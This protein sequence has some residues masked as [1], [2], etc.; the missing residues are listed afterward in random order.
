MSVEKE[1][2][3]SKDF[4]ERLLRQQEAEQRTRE[5]Q[6]AMQNKAE[7]DAHNQA[8]AAKTEQEHN[9]EHDL[10]NLSKNK[11]AAGQIQKAVFVDSADNEFDR[12]TGETQADANNK[13]FIK[14][15]MLRDA[16]DQ[17]AKSIAQMFEA[18]N[19]KLAELEKD[20]V[21]LDK[22]LDE[23]K[24]SRVIA[25]K[26]NTAFENRDFEMMEL[27][28]VQHGDY[29]ADS[30]K[31]MESEEIL[32]AFIDFADDVLDENKKLQLE[33]EARLSGVDEKTEAIRKERQDLKEK[34][35]NGEIS[36]A[37]Y[38]EQL[39]QTDERY[40]KA[41]NKAQQ[42]TEDFAKEKGLSHEAMQKL[43]NTIAKVR[44]E[45]SAFL[46]E[47]KNESKGLDRTITAQDQ[48]PEVE[49]DGLASMSFP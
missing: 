47:E 33:L 46:K 28:M 40:G 4:A 38:E 22:G 10:Y 15:S 35:K 21:E 25:N 1:D 8:E 32:M 11:Q 20:L 26:V 41:M 19:A 16:F 5:A 17:A 30:F 2:N 43:T 14:D 45:P 13:R 48:K 12:L 18:L 23:Y 34:F 37:D 31:D 44:E 24:Q 3:Q 9:K 6:E 7:Q 36:K 29:P 49:L 39:D 27:I 42:I